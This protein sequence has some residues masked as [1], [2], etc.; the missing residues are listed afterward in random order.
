MKLQ[1]NGLCSFSYAEAMLKNEL[2]MYD[3]FFIYTKQ[4][5]TKTKPRIMVTPKFINMPHCRR[6]LCDL[7]SVPT[8]MVT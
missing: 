1:P 5:V 3:H 6:E 7:L 8:V 2:C 4:A